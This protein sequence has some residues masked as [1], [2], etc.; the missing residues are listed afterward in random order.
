LRRTGV[1]A[2][3]SPAKSAAG[4]GRR[5]GVFFLFQN[6]SLTIRLA[7]KPDGSRTGAGVRVL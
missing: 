1:A 3:A 5:A 7:A 4:A 6:D 2:C